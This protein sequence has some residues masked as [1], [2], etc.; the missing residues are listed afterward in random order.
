VFPITEKDLHKPEVASLKKQ[1]AKIY[2]LTGRGRGELDP[3]NVDLIKI[4]HY[5]ESFFISG[6]HFWRASIRNNKYLPPYKH[7]EFSDP[8][9]LYLVNTFLPPS[10]SVD[11]S[12]TITFGADGNSQKFL[13]TG[14][15]RA[16]ESFTW[17][18]G[19]S[20]EIRFDVNPGT[21]PLR[22]IAHLNPLRYGRITR[23]KVRV[24]INGRFCC[25]WN[26]A[27]KKDYSCD[28]PTNLTDNVKD[29]RIRFD[30]PNAA[31]PLDL[32]ISR[33]SRLL[34]VQFYSLTF[35]EI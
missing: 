18:D 35:N 17:T 3:N 32:G 4:L 31:R 8:V 16:E 22:L 21:S 7:H 12:A 25:D 26:V 33:D 13:G 5:K 1:F 19:H 29:F 11:A 6:L 20:A 2:L 15:S 30:L 14:W 24:S 10:L 28:I 23:Q 9:Y 27:T 34:G